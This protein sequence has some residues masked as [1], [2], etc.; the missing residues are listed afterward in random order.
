MLADN[1][2][3]GA[4]LNFIIAAVLT[5]TPDM[6]NQTLMAGPLCILYEVGIICARLAVRKRKAQAPPTETAA[7]S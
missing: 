2:A 4:S 5:P 3:T 6:I 1:V 7:T